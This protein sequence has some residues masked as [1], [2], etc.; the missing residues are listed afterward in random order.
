MFST[1]NFARLAVLEQR[2]SIAMQK[3]GF[4]SFPFYFLKYSQNVLPSSSS[5]SLISV[6]NLC[7]CGFDSVYDRQDL[8]IDFCDQ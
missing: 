6:T 8:K 4:V 1:Q 5:H 3:F 2:N 7:N